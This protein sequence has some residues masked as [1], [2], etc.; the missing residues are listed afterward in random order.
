MPRAVKVKWG[1]TVYDVD[2]S[3]DEVGDE[4]RVI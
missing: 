4:R 2:L 1:K 3:T